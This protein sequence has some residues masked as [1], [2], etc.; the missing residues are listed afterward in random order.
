MWQTADRTRRAR[1]LR[2]DMTPSEVRLWDMLRD[3]RF[4]GLKFRR[5]VPVAGAVAD[6]L[7]AELRLV[8]ELDGGVH[9][10]R[11]TEDAARD[12]RLAAAGWVV[13][14]ETNEAF[15]RNPNALLGRV[16]QLTAER[17]RAP[18]HPSRSA[19]HLLPRGEKDV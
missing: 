3:R 11:E 12:A 1:G 2:R 7:C 9:R 19:S 6:F 13:L 4:D 8:L 18:P 5:Q 17:R 16:R 14:R 15:E 10:L